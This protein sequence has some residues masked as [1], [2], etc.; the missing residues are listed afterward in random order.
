MSKPDENIL[1][2]TPV[3]TVPLSAY[4]DQE[5]YEN[6]IRSGISKYDLIKVKLMSGNGDSYSILSRL[7]ICRML[8]SIGVES[9]LQRLNLQTLRPLPKRS[10]SRLLTTTS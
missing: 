2:P 3:S 6:K 7:M 8:T 9:I 10:R 1:Q 5:T 4:F